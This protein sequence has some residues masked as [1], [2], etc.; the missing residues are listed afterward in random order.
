MPQAADTINLGFLSEHEQ[1]MILE[2]LRRD[3]ELRQREDKRVRK[4]KTELLDVKRKGAKRGSVKYS[5][6][7]CGRCQEPLSRL[8]VLSSQCQMCNH[9]VCRKCRTV[10]DSGSWLLTLTCFSLKPFISP[11]CESSCHSRRR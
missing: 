8:S 1:E 5:P 11:D 4:L 6:R 10:L 3:E 2:V 7:S 9:H